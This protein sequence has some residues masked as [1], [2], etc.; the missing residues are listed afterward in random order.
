MKNTALGVTFFLLMAVSAVSA[1]AQ[2]NSQ[3]TAP[4]ATPATALPAPP[5]AAVQPPL[6][7]VDRAKELKGFALVEALRKGGFVLYMRHTETGLVTE[8]CETSNL[9]ASGEAAASNVG[10]AL[11]ELKISI[12]VV[13]SS[14]PCRAVD[15]ARLLGLGAVE[16]TEDLNPTPSR[17]GVD[18]GAVR[19]RRLAEMPPT[20]TNAV[21]VSHLHGSR[22][23]EEWLHLGMG[24]IIV[25]RPDGKDG[26]EPVARIAV[27][28]WIALKKLMAADAVTR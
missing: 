28:D 27:T 1:F 13:R 6:P 14:Q 25:F 2:A 19:S 5:V 12:G 23:K 8:K 22:K 10:A 21:L 26:H 17:E 9:S 15:T 3:A 7:I 16:I 24:E 4:E 20:G 18:I 11:R